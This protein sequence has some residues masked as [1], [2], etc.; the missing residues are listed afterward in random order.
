MITSA[1][2]RIL[3]LVGVV[4]GVVGMVLCLAVIVGAWWVNGPLTSSVLKIFPPVEAVL[5]FGDETAAR[6]GAFVTDTQEQLNETADAK[7]VAMALE[8]EIA[9]IALY[10][11]VADGL[12]ASAETTLS[13]VADAVQPNVRGAVTTRTTNRLLTTL[14]SVDETLNSAETLAQDVRD[15]RDEKI[16][17]LN[18]QLDRLEANSAEVQTVI[19]QTQTDVADL[20]IKIPRWIDLGSLIVTFIFLWFGVAQYFL[21]QNGWRW[22][23]QLSTG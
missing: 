13:E 6:F 14:N 4:L 9:Q 16:E 21:M 5:I 15:G 22:L 3:G 7:P 20:K 23:R 19:D 17:E 10:V 12:V 11:D 2:K 18:Q 8:D 1:V